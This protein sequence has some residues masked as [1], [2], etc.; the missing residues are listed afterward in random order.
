MKLLGT[1]GS[2]SLDILVDSRSTHNSLDSSMASSI[3]MKILTDVFM[4]VKVAN[5]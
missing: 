5:G 3:K 4:E 1:M 2:F